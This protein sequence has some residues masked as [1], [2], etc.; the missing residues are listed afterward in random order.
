MGTVFILFSC[1]QWFSKDS[2]RIMGECAYQDIEKLLDFAYADYY[3]SLDDE[4]YAVMTKEDFEEDEENFRSKLRDEKQ[5][6]QKD[7][8]YVIKELELIY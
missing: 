3:G 6:G 7:C 1:D 2:M 8:Y 4:E 5:I